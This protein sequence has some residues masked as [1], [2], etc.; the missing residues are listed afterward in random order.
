MII[1][2]EIEN[3]EIINIEGTNG[4]VNVIDYDGD[5]D[6]FNGKSCTI[7]TMNFSKGDNNQ[8]KTREFINFQISGDNS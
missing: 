2:I 8:H 6:I 7:T 4:I 1:Q 3:N 5:T